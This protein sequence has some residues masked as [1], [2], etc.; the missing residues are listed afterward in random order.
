MRLLTLRYLSILNSASNLS[1]C[2]ALYAWRGF[3]SIPGFRDLLPL[4]FGAEIQMSHSL[5]FFI[6]SYDTFSEFLD[7]LIIVAL[8]HG[9]IYR[10]ELLFTR[11]LTRI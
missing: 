2:L 9:N 4:G 8:D 10:S 7:K 5:L 6:R 3:L 11:K 1:N